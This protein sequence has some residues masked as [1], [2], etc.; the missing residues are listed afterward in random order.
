MNR[1]FDIAL[2]LAS[3]RFLGEREKVITDALTHN[4]NYFNIVCS[5]IDELD[6]VKDLNNRFKENSCFSLGVHPHNANELNLN[7]LKS[8]KD[9]INIHHPSAVGET[10]L[11]FFRNLSSF[12]NQLDA[13]EQ[14]IKI[15]IENNLPLFLHQREAHDDFIKVI[16]KY[17]SDIPKGVVH[18]FTGTQSQLD[19]YLER[20]LYIGLTGW[21]C[22]ER[23][24]KDLRKSIKNI[25]IDKLMIETDAPYLI[26]RNLKI[27]PKN[28]RNEP[29]FLPHIANEI[30]ALMNIDLEEFNIQVFNNSKIFFGINS[31]D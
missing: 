6:F 11:D 12:E 27:K 1:Y 17:I 31:E 25:P 29:K 18:C 24:N 22:D 19:D 15:S 8:L 23:R 21:I 14:Q 2:N 13:F 4:V 3:D 20:D 10:G 9:S 5:S 28:N 30:A 16:D 7:T 26:P